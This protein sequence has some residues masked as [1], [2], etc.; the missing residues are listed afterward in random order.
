MST[1]MTPCERMAL[2]I[3]IDKRAGD[4]ARGPLWD[5]SR[6]EQARHQGGQPIGRNGDAA[7]LVH[8]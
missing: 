5:A 8:E 6:D 7:N 1:S 2:E 3:G 4:G